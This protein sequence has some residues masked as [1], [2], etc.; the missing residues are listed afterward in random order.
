M[1]TCGFEAPIC[2]FWHL[3][4]F[5]IDLDPMTT[6]S[7]ST[8]DAR[9]ILQTWKRYETINRYR[10]REKGVPNVVF[11]QADPKEPLD[12]CRVHNIPV[13]DITNSTLRSPPC[14]E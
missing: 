3:S 11:H 10:S 7:V 1:E 9:G 8:H 4:P 13:D 2:Q 14:H 6:H 5:G 12:R